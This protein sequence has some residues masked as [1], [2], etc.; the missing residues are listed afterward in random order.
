MSIKDDSGH[1]EGS[2]LSEIFDQR[3]EVIDSH[4]HLYSYNYFRLLSQISGQYD[5]V[6]RFI[7]RQTRRLKID[8]PP[9]DPAR[10]GERWVSEIDRYGVSRVCLLAGLPGDEYSVGE[11]TRAKTDRFITFM[12]VNPH[13]DVAQEVI[14]HAAR[15]GGVRGVYLHPSRHRFH[16]AD[17]RVYPIYRLARRLRL[18]VYVD[19]GP[20]C[21]PLA[22]AW[23]ARDNHDPRFNDPAQLHFAASDFPT[24]P[25]VITH[26]LKN[27]I[28]EVL[29]LG[30]LC[31]NVHLSALPT[32]NWDDQSSNSAEVESILE[33]ALRA[34]GHTRIIFGTGSGVLPRG[35]RSDRFQ[36]FLMALKNL[37]VS[38]DRI[39][40]IL[41]GNVKRIFGLENS[42]PSYLITL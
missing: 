25:F 3:W 14:E 8:L 40:L 35:W 24:V 27:N 9:I 11:A 7:R 31:P 34:F 13:L 10:L 12:A 37:G 21:S 19:Y 18:V 42:R 23:G 16:A 2:F 6:D 17:E 22:A 39:G 41:G 20:P 29:R 33:L 36:V 32:D 1:G 38:S 28:R 30:L 26:I 5:D 4:V 15:A